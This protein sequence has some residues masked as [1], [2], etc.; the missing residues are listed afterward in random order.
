MRSPTTYDCICKG[1]PCIKVTSLFKDK[2]VLT[3]IMPGLSLGF[4]TRPNGPQILANVNSFSK[5]KLVL[6]NSMTDSM[7]SFG[8]GFPT[9]PNGPQIPVTTTQP[10]LQPPSKKANNG[11]YFPS[12]SL[13]NL[14]KNYP[15]RRNFP[16]TWIWEEINMRFS[17]INYL[18]EYTYN[19]KT[20]NYLSFL[21][22]FFQNILSLNQLSLII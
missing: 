15:V 6:S 14:R 21:I 13:S 17:N 9:R 10:D 8:L 1:K 22:F 19:I 2:H 3:N 11:Q 20:E 16:R 12:P 4:P 5:D 7:P 18:L